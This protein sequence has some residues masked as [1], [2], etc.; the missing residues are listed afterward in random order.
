MSAATGM[1][2]CLMPMEAVREVSKRRNATAGV[3]EGGT[4]RQWM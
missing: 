1:E 2:E 3:G 4:G